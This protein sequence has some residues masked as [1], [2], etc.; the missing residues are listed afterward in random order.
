MV[1][2]GISEALGQMFMGPVGTC[3]DPDVE[4]DKEGLGQADRLEYLYLIDE[5]ELVEDHA[6]GMKD[7]NSPVSGTKA[8]FVKHHLRVRFVL[9]D[10]RGQTRCTQWKI[11]EYRFTLSCYE[12]NP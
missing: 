9:N 3:N 2:T 5:A 7:P 12:R 8:D 6:G 10:V 11:G 4:N 1:M